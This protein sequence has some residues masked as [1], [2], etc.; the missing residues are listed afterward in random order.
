[1]ICT[2]HQMEV[3]FIS[4]SFPRHPLTVDFLKISKKLFFFSD[5][6]KITKILLN[7]AFIVLQKLQ[8]FKNGASRARR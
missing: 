3:K 4:Q 8:K 5:N 1:M 2:N 6:D 7:F